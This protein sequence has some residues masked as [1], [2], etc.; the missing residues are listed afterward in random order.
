MMNGFV[1]QMLTMEHFYLRRM[2]PHNQISAPA[3]SLSMS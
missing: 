3:L 2:D 1:G